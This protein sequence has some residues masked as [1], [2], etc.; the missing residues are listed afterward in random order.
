LKF[1]YTH[2]HQEQFDFLAEMRDLHY[3]IDRIEQ[4]LQELIDNPV[5]DFS[6]AA[7]AGQWIDEQVQLLETNET[8]LILP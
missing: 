2:F 6:E 7:V 1:E 4:L 8:K 3:R 5:V